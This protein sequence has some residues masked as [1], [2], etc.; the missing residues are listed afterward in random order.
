M[1]TD[2]ETRFYS[3]GDVS[4]LRNACC[5]ANTYLDSRRVHVDEVCMKTNQNG[6][7]F[8][9]GDPIMFDGDPVDEACMTAEPSRKFKSGDPIT[10]RGQD[11]FFVEYGQIAVMSRQQVII[12]INGEKLPPVFLDETKPRNT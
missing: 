1:G 3:R 8:Q 11:G 7:P 5:V 4:S 10:Y 9:P 2:V 6:R 12:K